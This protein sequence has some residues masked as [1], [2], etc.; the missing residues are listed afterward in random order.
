MGG[1]G[2]KMVVNGYSR[3]EEQSFRHIYNDLE[4]VWF[5]NC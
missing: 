1:Y 3:S 2:T 4:P 5:G